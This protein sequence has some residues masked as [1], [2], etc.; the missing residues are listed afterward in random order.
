MAILCYEH[1][2]PL[3]GPLMWAFETKTFLSSFFFVVILVLLS[4][5]STII[6]LSTLNPS[7][8]LFL[9]CYCPNIKKK[10]ELIFV[11]TGH[12]INHNVAVQ[13]FKNECDHWLPPFDH[14]VM[15]G[16]GGM[17]TLNCVSSSLLFFL[18]TSTATYIFTAPTCTT[19][20]TT[21]KPWSVSAWK[22]LFSHLF[23]LDSHLFC[24]SDFKQN[25]CSD[26]RA[27][28]MISWTV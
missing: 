12:P 14:R 18:R 26:D 15:F 28:P 21:L 10:L 6:F 20:I 23:W 11:T 22:I 17:F 3:D 24:R 2:D 13:R 1:V 16:G 25:K 27:D 7:F 19:P 8:F 5:L 4:F 9:S